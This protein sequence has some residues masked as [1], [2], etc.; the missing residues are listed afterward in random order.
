MHAYVVSTET[1]SATVIS[2]PPLMRASLSPFRAIAHLYP[3]SPV[4]TR[5]QGADYVRSRNGVHRGAGH[6]QG[7]PGRVEGRRRA[8]RGCCLER[9]MPRDR[10]R[11][12]DRY[13]AVRLLGDG[14]SLRERLRWREQACRW[15]SCCTL[16][17]RQGCP[18]KRCI[19]ILTRQ[20]LFK[21]TGLVVFGIA[22]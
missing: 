17:I 15:V 1:M 18:S 8:G 9:H 13:V 19:Y 12:R 6:A 7:R 14:E 4:E 5:S 21:H 3:S 10:P 22:P 11:R 20:G 2:T 16:D